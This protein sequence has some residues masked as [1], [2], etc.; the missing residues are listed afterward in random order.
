VRWLADSAG[1]E[2]VRRSI[3]RSQAPATKLVEALKQ[4]NELSLEVW[5]ASHN[6]TQGGPARIVS[7]SQNSEAHNFTLGQDGADI[8]FR[9]RT[10]V[11]GHNRA[12]VGLR[13]TDRVLSR[14]ISHVI[15]TYKAGIERLYVN[16]AQ[17][18]ETVNM[19]RDAIIGFGTRKTGLSQL[20]YSFFYFLP[21]SLVFSVFVS[22][23]TIRPVHRWILSVAVAAALAGT[24]EFI[25]AFTLARAIEPKIIWYGVLIGFGGAST[26]TLFAQKRGDIESL[27][28]RPER[29]LSEA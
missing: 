19:A 9:L 17:R 20:A 13:T 25:Q 4:T 3:V 29:A 16:G 11:S 14:D 18:P 23:R 10:P 15:V 27:P 8:H 1:I 22:T 5:M 28:V 21:A 26:G 7:L 6:T 24:T 12:P 2:I